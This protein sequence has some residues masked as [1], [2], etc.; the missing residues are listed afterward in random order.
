MSTYY[1]VPTSDKSLSSVKS[2]VLA[3]GV[4]FLFA[5]LVHLPPLSAT[6]LFTLLSHSSL[7]LR[8]RNVTRSSRNYCKHLESS[9]F[10]LFAVNS[11]LLSHGLNIPS[12]LLWSSKCNNELDY[13]HNINTDACLLHLRSHMQGQVSLGCTQPSLPP[14][15]C[16]LDISHSC[17]GLYL[18][19][20]ADRCLG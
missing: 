20:P 17:S 5:Y 19:K 14:C 9:T 8:T 13:S 11:L 15:Y 2:T 18:V 1:I 3:T 12:I 4:A 16:C 10:T 6:T 7:T